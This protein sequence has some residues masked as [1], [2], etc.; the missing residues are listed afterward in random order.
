M[1]SSCTN[2]F[3][4]VKIPTKAPGRLPPLAKAFRAGT[5][6]VTFN[7]KGEDDME[8]LVPIRGRINRTFC[9]KCW[10]HSLVTVKFYPL[11]WI[12]GLLV[13]FHQVL[14]LIDDVGSEVDP[15]AM[16]PNGSLNLVSASSHGMNIQYSLDSSI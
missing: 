3:D 1:A 13:T 10:F 8:L 7:L 9:N 2:H 15:I 16:I 14:P 6:C 12:H 4:T 5:N 11:S